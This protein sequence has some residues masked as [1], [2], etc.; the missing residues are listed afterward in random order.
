M[1]SLLDRDGGLGINV[2]FGAALA[3]VVLPLLTLVLVME[4]RQRAQS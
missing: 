2:P 4:E 1:G 3:L